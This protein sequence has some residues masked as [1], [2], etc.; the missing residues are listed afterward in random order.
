MTRSNLLVFLRKKMFEMTGKINRRIKWNVPYVQLKLLFLLSALGWRVVNW[1]HMNKLNWLVI[2]LVL[3]SVSS[4]KHLKVGEPQDNI[5]C[6]YIIF[7]LWLPSCSSFCSSDAFVLKYLWQVCL[8]GPRTS[9]LF[10][11]G[12]AYFIMLDIFY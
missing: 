7:G 10:S 9:K 6:N 1:R 3:L 12:N 2:P 4:I 8:F 5:V 11:Y